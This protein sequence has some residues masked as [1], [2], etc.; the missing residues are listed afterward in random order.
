MKRT[1][2]IIGIL[3]FAVTA[4]TVYRVCVSDKGESVE[5]VTSL[6]GVYEGE[7]TI[8]LP[9]HLKKMAGKYPSE[10]TETSTGRTGFHAGWK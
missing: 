5:D 7:A 10:R 6:L 9:D 1:L 4:A 3:V 2:L 8:S